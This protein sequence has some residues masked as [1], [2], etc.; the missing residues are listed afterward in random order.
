M[1]ALRSRFG[2][3]FSP[4]LWLR[5]AEGLRE[6]FDGG[7]GHA[8]IVA[9]EFCAYTTLDAAAVPVR[10]R[11]GYAGMAIARWAPF[12]DPD[13]WVEWVGD[14]AMVWAWSK[15]KVLETQDGTRIPPEPR[16]LVPES[17]HRGQPLDS[18]EELMA[19]DSGCEGRVWR[20]GVLTASRWWPEPPA[21]EDWNQFR[22]GVG[23]PPAS[24]MPGSI[25]LPLSERPW[26]STGFG[27][28][29]A[30]V[31][32]QRRVLGLLATG[33]CAAVLAALLVASLALKFSIWQVDQDI[34][35]RAQALDKIIEARD[36][37]LQD[38]AAIEATLAMRPPAGQM[39]LLAE[40]SRLMRGQWQLREWRMP[41][42]RNVDL[43]ASMA[44]ADPREIVTAWEGSGRFTDVTAEIGRSK[45]EVHIK[46]K[47]VRKS[48]RK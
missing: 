10:K 18:G 9:R 11:R 32:R 16:R 7:N 17:L 27:G 26:T 5:S 22:R 28:I 37:A 4:S 20:S 8:W 42:E 23:L 29:S 45:N 13:S 2:R 46:A 43:V 48:E 3:S 44:N 39:Q 19:M 30:V 41:D 40:V 35:A 33:L 14:R 6:V 21:L 24:Q 38:R 1:Q 31:G 15:S 47:V 36:R 34:Q 25:T 12:P